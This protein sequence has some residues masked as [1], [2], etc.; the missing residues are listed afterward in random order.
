MFCLWK[1]Y[2]K[3]WVCLLVDVEPEDTTKPK[4]GRRKV[5]LFLAA[6]KENPEYLAQ[7][8]VSWSSKIGAVLS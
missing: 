3:N 8:S 2:L 5:L 1:Y 7:S 4:I 6:S